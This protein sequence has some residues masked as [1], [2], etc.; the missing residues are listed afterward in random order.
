[1]GTETLYFWQ[2][3]PELLRLKVAYPH[4]K[5]LHLSSKVNS[6]HKT[7]LVLNQQPLKDSITVRVRSISWGE[8]KF[9]AIFAFMAEGERA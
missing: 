3:M 9:S 1:M 6:Q 8:L 4:H 7:E 2:K 5:M